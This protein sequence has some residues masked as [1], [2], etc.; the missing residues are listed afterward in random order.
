MRQQCNGFALVGCRYRKIATG[1]HSILNDFCCESL[2]A[3]GLLGAPYSIAWH[4]HNANPL[5][6]LFRT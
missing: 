5:G 6:N 4:P 2:L 3:A 1:I